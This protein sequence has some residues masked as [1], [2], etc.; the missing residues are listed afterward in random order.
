MDQKKNTQY[1]IKAV[2]IDIDGTLTD[3]HRR[4]NLDAVQKIRDLP[5]P[6]V[7][8]SGNQICFVK[9]ASKLLGEVI[10]WLARTAA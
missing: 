6:V 5:V 9:A 7:I 10:S 8:A 4:V 2:L 1:P 3:I